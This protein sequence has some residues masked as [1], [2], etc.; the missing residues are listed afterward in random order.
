MQI[1]RGSHDQRAIPQSKRM[2][3]W[4]EMSYAFWWAREPHTANSSIWLLSG[5][6]HYTAVPSTSYAWHE[7][8]ERVLVSL[9]LLVIKCHQQDM[10]P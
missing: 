7:S 6:S 1:W 10:T 9:P 2:L 3:T 5:N 4:F 8:D